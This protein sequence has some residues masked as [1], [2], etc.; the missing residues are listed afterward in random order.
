MLT[1]AQTAKRRSAPKAATGSFDQLAKRAAEARD[2]NRVDE[3]IIL[4]RQ[5]LKAKPLWSEGW[6][7]LG[8][9]LYDL[10]R[11]AEARDALQ[12]LAALKPDGG[13]TWALIGLCEYR[14]RDYQ[15]ALVHLIRARSLGLGQNEQMAFVTNYHAALLLTRFEQFEG[16]LEIL[17][18][19]T[20]SHPGNPT[21][22]EALGINLLRL[23]F[24]PSELPPERRELVLRMG[25]AADHAIFARTE[26]MRRE[27]EEL[28]KDYPQTANIHY[29][30]GVFLLR[31]APDEAL[32]EFQREL[33]ISARHVPARL[34][35]AFEHIKRNDHKSGL[36][37]AEQ[38]VEIDPNSFPSRNA[39]GRILLELGQT[40]RAIKEL[41]AGVK[42]AP[43]S[44]EMRFALARAYSRA[45]RKTEAAKERA[46]FIRLDK[47]R[48]TQR[49]GLPAPLPA[50]SGQT[51]SIP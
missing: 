41:E 49:E 51:P 13:P 1:W 7:Y 30:Y 44:P 36:I 26:E 23:P 6:W 15:Q 19:L 50:E 2:A 47:L 39:L 27:M 20:K 35:I 45:G 24:L 9:L 40:E 8:T 21:I 12:R 42:L 46:E 38:A 22:I 34:Q 18:Q 25:R 14:L 16:G 29:A 37:F 17:P 48:N 33:E 5:A 10:E 43:H 3:S 32:K 11:H 4:Y 28:I 31:S